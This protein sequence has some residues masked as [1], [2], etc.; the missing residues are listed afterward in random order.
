VLLR[1]LHRGAMVFAF[2][3][4]TGTILDLWLD[5]EAKTWNWFVL[6][7]FGLPMCGVMLWDL[8]RCQDFRQVHMRLFPLACLFLLF[9]GYARY[10]A[11]P[12]AVLLLLPV[13][14]TRAPELPERESRPEAPGMAW[15]MLLV[16]AIL[17]ANSETLMH[18]MGF[19]WSLQDGL[20]EVGTLLYPAAIILLC[21]TPLA[22]RL[23]DDWN[24]LLRHSEAYAHRAVPLMLVTGLLFLTVRFCCTGT[25]DLSLAVARP[26][27][28]AL[29]LTVIAGVLLQPASDELIYRGLL[30]RV[31]RN[32]W[33]FLVVSTLLYAVVRTVVQTGG[34]FLPELLAY[35]V[36][37]LG[38]S[39]CYAF[40]DN[41][42]VSYFANA[43]VSLIAVLAGLPMIQQI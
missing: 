22:I 15:L 12:A 30:R 21:L 34:I 2:L 1:L 3:M 16:M 7:L 23:R 19:G 27:E 37:G 17:L 29:P 31:V 20:A 4:L 5:A 26:Y 28:V 40:T 36:L 13:F 42:F 43:Y 33:A 25:A 6:D 39:A 10:M 38:L 14:F 18:L 8:L 11:Y 24:V 41:F 9:G 35:S 32:R